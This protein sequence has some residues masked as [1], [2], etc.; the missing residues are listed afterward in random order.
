MIGICACASAFGLYLLARM[1]AQVGRKSS[2]F[3]CASITYPSAAV[4]FDMAIAVKCFGVSISYLV[5]VGALIPQIVHGY[6]PQTPI[7][8]VWRQRETWITISMFIIIPFCF[9]KRLDSLRYVFCDW[10]TRIDIPRPFRCLP[11]FIFSVL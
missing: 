3:T 7:D 4:Y 8:S 1:A 10:I 11:S 6:F 5:I 9:M 2:F